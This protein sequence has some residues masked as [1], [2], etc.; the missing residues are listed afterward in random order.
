[1]VLHESL[2]NTIYWQS[3]HYFTE[4]T[5]THTCF[6][7][8]YN[9]WNLFAG[10]HK[11]QITMAATYLSITLKSAWSLVLTTSLS[12]AY[13]PVS[14]SARSS[15]ENRS[16]WKPS[17][18]ESL[19]CSSFESAGL[20]RPAL[21][22]LDM[23][24]CV[25][26]RV[27]DQEWCWGMSVSTVCRKKKSYFSLRACAVWLCAHVSFLMLPAVVMFLFEHDF[28]ECVGAKQDTICRV[29]STRK[30]PIKVT[31]Y[32]SRV[33]WWFIYWQ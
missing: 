18:S 14:G 33:F 11:T 17:H 4:G 28:P 10:L 16:M 1:M 2:H 3:R 31:K 6:T 15:R 7:C 12:P 26:L 30:A 27:S 8:I 21:L 25:C 20:E 23:C 5:S 24:V 29:A 9:C 13:C 22:H 19:M 32:N